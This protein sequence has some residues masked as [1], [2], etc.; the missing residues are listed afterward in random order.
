LLCKKA[1]L[2]IEIDLQDFRMKRTILFL[3]I[4]MSA[5]PLLFSFDVPSVSMHVYVSELQTAQ[6][7]FILENHII[8]SVKGVYRSVGIAFSHEKWSKTYYF[9]KNKYGIFFFIYPI[10]LETASPLQY[11]L[12]IDGV[13][14]KDSSN[15]ECYK[16]FN[17]GIEFSLVNIPFLPK[18]IYGIWNPADTKDGT[19]TFYYK[20][21]PGQYI[22][23]T[24]SFCNWDPFLYELEEEKPGEYWLKLRLEPGTYYYVF[25]IKGEKVPD[26][27][28]NRIVYTKEERPVSELVVPIRKN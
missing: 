8:F 21:E 2:S 13:W 16:D 17:T 19:V 3:L 12:V 26:P 25:I 24:G 7:P 1:A 4:V 9:E 23:V 14:C 28:N 18:Q 15:P 6:A 22:Y 20:G 5:I 10:P 27:L 11:R